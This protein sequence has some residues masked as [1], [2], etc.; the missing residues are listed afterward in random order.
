[1]NSFW[2]IFENIP[3]RAAFWGWLLAQII[4]GF[5]N[6]WMDG[7]FDLSRFFGSGGMP[8]S[9]TS[10]V[11]ALST[12]LGI[13]YGFDSPFF[14]VAAV[15]SCIVM[16]D[17]SGVRRET[18]KQAVILNEIIKLFKG[19]KKMGDFKLKELVGHSPLEVGAGALLGITVGILFTPFAG[20]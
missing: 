2:T 15:F 19:G 9:H 5:V 8:S 7:K 11:T 20:A 12:S 3:L 4:K 18:G 10:A 17:A 13:L 1:M 14:A 16:Y 6:M